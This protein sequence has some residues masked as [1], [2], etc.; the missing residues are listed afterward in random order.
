M[1][2]KENGEVQVLNVDNIDITTTVN[3]PQWLKM[4][5]VQKQLYKIKLNEPPGLGGLHV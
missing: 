5:M 1:H 4:C 2:T 3:D